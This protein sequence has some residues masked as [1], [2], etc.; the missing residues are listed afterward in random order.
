MLAALA[1]NIGIAIAKLVAFLLTGSASLLAEFVHSLAD[2]SDQVLLL[3]GRA[4]AQPGGRPRSTRSAT[5][6]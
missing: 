6:A 5:A 4:R 2:C 1:A 3:V